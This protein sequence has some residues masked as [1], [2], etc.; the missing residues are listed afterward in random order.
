NQTAAFIS[1]I[2]VACAVRY[3]FHVIA[4]C[5]VW[6]GVSVPSGDGLI[7]SLIYNATYM[8]PETIVTVIGGFYLAKTL[9][10]SAQRLAPRSITADQPKGS[11]VLMSAA[12][13]VL[14]GVLVYDTAA[15]FGRLQ[16]A[17]SGEFDITGISS[18]PWL[19]VGILTATA[20]LIVAVI[21]AVNK[22]RK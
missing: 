6:A 21:A 19:T 16:N 11:R 14:A 7:Y 18:V 1:G 3:I 17:D 20:L 8:L 2:L 10:F 15:I 9:D 22:K 5:T 12:L 4:G 13:F